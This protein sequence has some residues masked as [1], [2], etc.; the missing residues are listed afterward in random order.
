MAFRSSIVSDFTA[1]KPSRA[2][3]VAA[4]G[5]ENGVGAHVLNSLLD[6]VLRALA[7]AHRRNYGSHAD[8]DAH[9]GEQGAHF[10]PCQYSQCQPHY[11]QEIHGSLSPQVPCPARLPS[12]GY[13]PPRRNP[14]AP[15][16]WAARLWQ[17]AA[18]G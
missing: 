3:P 5:D 16:A 11:V 1:Q 2:R 15:E 4:R 10:I 8:D 18:S 17:S 12:P 9:H 14:K 13:L 6:K 7:D